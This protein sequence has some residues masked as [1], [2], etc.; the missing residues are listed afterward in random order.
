MQ[1]CNDCLTL[2]KQETRK[3]GEKM[4]SVEKKAYASPKLKTWGKVRD[5]T[6][7][8]LTNPGADGKSGSS[9]SQGR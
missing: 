7:T 9:A 6:Q 3:G 2:E 5:L 1:R 4:G 8:G